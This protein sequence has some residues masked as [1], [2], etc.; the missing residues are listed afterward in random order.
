MKFDI[1]NIIKS[2]GLPLGL[3]AVIASILALFGISLDQVVVI[4]SSLIGLQLLIALA[5]NILKWAGV[6][7]DGTAGK[8]SAGFNLLSL[9]GIAALLH[10]N[11]EFDFVSLDAQL[12]DVAKFASLVFFYVVQ[13][14]GTKSMHGFTTKGL[15]IKAFTQ[16][17]GK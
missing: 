6:V 15:G 7:D 11:P 8:W 16:V 2:L 1:G 14:I 4:A 12:T 10:S 17:K 5:V 3:V 9:F 13:I